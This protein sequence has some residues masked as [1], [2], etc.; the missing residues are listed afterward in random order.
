MARALPSADL[1]LYLLSR[2]QSPDLGGLGAYAFELETEVFPVAVPA[3]DAMAG[4][5]QVGARAGRGRGHDEGLARTFEMDVERALVAGEAQHAARARH[6]PRRD[7]PPPRA[8]RGPCGNPR[9]WP[10]TRW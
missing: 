6:V 9:P 5:G 7:T 3:G 2:P 10:G 8:R 1:D 4:R